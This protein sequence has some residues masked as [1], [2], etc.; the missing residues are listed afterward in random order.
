ML[1]KIDECDTASDVVKSINILIA[2]RWV[3]KAWSLVRA[4]TI[5]KCFRKVGILNADLDVI[6]CDLEED[7]PF[8]EADMRMEVQSLIEKTMPTDGRCNVDEYLNGD[9]DLPVCMELD[10]DS[11]GDQPL[12]DE[13]FSCLKLKFILSYPILS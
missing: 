1:S 10:S 6:T 11:Q 2:L 8:L 5:A 4:E 3:A 7:D 9:D 13:T 12:A